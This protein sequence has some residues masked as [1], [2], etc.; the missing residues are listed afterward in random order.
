MMARNKKSIDT[1]AKK[2]WMWSIPIL[3]CSLGAVFYAY[4]Y[5][6]RI[7][8][9][10][11]YADLY[12]YFGITAAGYGFLSSFYYWAYTPM[13]IPVGMLMDRY[14]PRRLLTLACLVCALGSYLFAS[15]ESW[16]VAL[17]ARFLMGF[18]SAFAFVGVLKLATIWLPPDKFGLI[19][20]ATSSF[21][22]LFGAVFAELIL[23]HLVDVLHWRPTLFLS[24][25]VGLVLTVILALVIRD[26][27]K[28]ASRN[29]SSQTL[30]E[31]PKTM[32]EVVDHSI[33]LL[34]NKYIWLNG[35]IGCLLY[36][37]SSGFAENWAKPYL[38]SAH[39]FSSLEA[40]KGVS[41]LFL[42]FTVGG[43]LFGYISDKLK[44]RK[45]P[46]MVGGILTVIF[47]CMLLYIPALSKPMVFTLLFLVGISYGA[48]ILVFPIGR[49]LSSRKV[50]GTAVAVTNMLVM[51]SGF[52]FTPL[53]GVA[54][55]YV[56]NGIIISGEHVYTATNFMTALTILPLAGIGAV[57]LTA[58]LKE[59]Y[60][61]PMDE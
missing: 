26:K 3:M 53:I 4:E 21:G 31:Q 38:I 33:I 32:R 6:L 39:N 15:T 55:D 42:G 7:T 5:L 46:M 37:P 45:F 35:L 1:N 59:T 23:E 41:T 2:P 29:Y 56:W 11:I 40:A 52:L 34:K 8:P 48:E 18:G 58:F 20:G 10:V 27:P 50:A 30:A 28:D 24:A 22:T 36:L 61:E 9:N 25:V 12:R 60:A 17:I 19:S 44:R 47:M 51:V 14:G 49:E 13:Q 16:A 54:L 43:I 57:F